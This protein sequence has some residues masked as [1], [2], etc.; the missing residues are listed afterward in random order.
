M[1]FPELCVGEKIYCLFYGD[2]QKFPCDSVMIT[3]VRVWNAAL[4]ISSITFSHMCIFIGNTFY[5]ECNFL[6]ISEIL[7]TI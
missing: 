2:L 4:V 7:E 6:D 3:F 1:Y 5:F